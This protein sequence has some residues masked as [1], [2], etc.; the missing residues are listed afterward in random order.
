MSDEIR[1]KFVKKHK[2]AFSEIFVLTYGKAD[3]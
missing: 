3:V 2:N 1:L